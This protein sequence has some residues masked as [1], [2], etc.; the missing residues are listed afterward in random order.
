LGLCIGNLKTQYP[1]KE[2]LKKMTPELILRHNL[3][4]IDIDP[5]AA[6]ICSLALWMRAQRS[7][8]D[9][10]RAE[11]PQIRR[12]N[13]AIAEPMPGEPDLLD[14]FCSTVEPKL[15]GQLVREVFNRMKIA[16]DA[17]ALLRIE[18][19]IAEIVAEARRQW[20]TEEVPTD[21]AGNPMLFA[22]SKQRTVFEM[23]RIT[24]DFWTFA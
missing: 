24:A 14:D 7:W 20:L 13:I 18:T 10:S 9:I 6:Q 4:G 22:A 15:L 11:R 12:T 21:R 17:G 16:G 2:E 5:R 8:Q 23:E 3:H 19:D 1:E